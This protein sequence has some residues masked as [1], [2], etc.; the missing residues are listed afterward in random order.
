MIHHSPMTKLVVLSAVH[1]CVDFYAGVIVPLPEPTLTRHLGVGLPVVT[2][3]IG[4]TAFLVNLV[5]P[6]GGWLLPKRG[7][8]FILLI[9]PPLAA[10]A[11]AIGLT[12]SIAVTTGLLAV[13]SIAI[14]IVHPE[15]AL[16]S[17]TLSGQ[18]QGLGMG[19]F[20]SGGYLGFA[21]GSLISGIWVERF[22]QDISHLWILSLPAFV[23]MSLVLY[24][25]LH[26]IQGHSHEDQN[27]SADTVPFALTLTL[28]VSIAV[29]NLLV[30][31]LSTIYLVRSFPE[32]GAQAWGGAT[33][34]ALGIAGALGAFLWGYFSDKLGCARMILIL[35][36]V[37]IPFYYMFL[38]ID[39]P[40][41]APVLG[42]IIGLT[43]GGT[44]PLTVV[45]AR[46]ARGTAHRFRI[47][48][49]IGGAWGTGELAFIMAGKY[50]GGFLPTETAPVMTVFKLCWIPIA[51]SIL[52]AFVIDRKEQTHLKSASHYE[53]Q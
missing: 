45:L 26:R 9:A 21:T 12:H 48:L 16:A 23:V 32:Q 20:I 18:K 36:T 52:L 14:G 31:R 10:L 43:L 15:A 53:G 19:F 3:I 24:V 37:G 38:R 13:S 7:L 25:G 27:R 6:L 11:A 1:F 34:F 5:Q 8:P 2:L 40:Q 41:L 50:I 33:V 39:S 46:R 4:C 17:C 49:S 29:F 47:G 42:A 22:N 28:A 30:V 44:F 51:C 35:S